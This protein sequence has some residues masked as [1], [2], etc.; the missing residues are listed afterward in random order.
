MQEP[1]ICWTKPGLFCFSIRDISPLWKTGNDVLKTTITSHKYSHCI[2]EDLTCHLPKPLLCCHSHHL[3]SSSNQIP[4]FVFFC[5]LHSMKLIY[6]DLLKGL[7]LHPV[8]QTSPYLSEIRKWENIFQQGGTYCKD[9]YCWNKMFFWKLF[10][11]NIGM[12][13]ICCLSCCRY[14]KLFHFVR[15]SCILEPDH[16]YKKWTLIVLNLILQSKLSHHT[17]IHVKLWTHVRCQFD[18]IINA[19]K[20]ILNSN[21]KKC[22]SPICKVYGILCGKVMYKD[23]NS[24]I[25]NKPGAYI[26]MQQI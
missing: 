4:P 15:I 13:H 2:E 11:R 6:C 19:I 3:I 26:K 23:M 16:Y 24:G 18:Q 7:A 25:T 17:F 1:R 5:N 12:F 21:E 20:N 22:L 10:E 8:G 14:R 9:L